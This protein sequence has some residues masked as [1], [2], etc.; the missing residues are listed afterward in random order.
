MERIVVWLMFISVSE[1]FVTYIFRDFFYAED[2]GSIF[3]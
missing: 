2:G 3:L 1:E